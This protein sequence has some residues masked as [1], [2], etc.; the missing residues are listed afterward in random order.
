[1]L[2]VKSDAIDKAELLNTGVDDYMTKP[3]SFEELKARINT[4]L[5]R[6]PKIEEK[7]AADMKRDKTRDI[8]MYMARKHASLSYRSA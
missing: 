2:S 6:P 7:K 3:F 4:L 5:R 1:M 8:H